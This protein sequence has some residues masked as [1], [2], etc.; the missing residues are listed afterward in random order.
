MI[1]SSFIETLIDVKPKII[2][3]NIK[4]LIK[5]DDLVLEKIILMSLKFFSV[6]NFQVRSSKIEI[7]IGELKKSSFKI[8]KLSNVLI[9]KRDDFLIFSLK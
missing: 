3:L 8:F 5:F 4:T 1:W 2:K 9:T 7:F 6:Q